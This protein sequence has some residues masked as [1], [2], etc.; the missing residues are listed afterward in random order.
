MFGLVLMFVDLFYFCKV[1]KS[2]PWFY[3]DIA[4]GLED[5]LKAVI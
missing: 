3:Q 5:Q 4:G 2:H 1:R